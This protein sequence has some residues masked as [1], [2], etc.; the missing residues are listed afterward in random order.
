MPTGPLSCLSRTVILSLCAEGSLKK[1]TLKMAVPNRTCPI[2][3]TQKRLC[4]S[5]KIGKGLGSNYPRDGGETLLAV[6]VLLF[7]S[8]YGCQVRYINIL[9]FFEFRTHPPLA[10]FG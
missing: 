9:S 1:S 5:D 3:P 2:S 8:V 4:S 7:S 10:L 6:N